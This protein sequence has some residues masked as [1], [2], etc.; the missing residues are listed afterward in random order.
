MYFQEGRLPLGKLWRSVQDTQDGFDLYSARQASFAWPRVDLARPLRPFWIISFEFTKVCW[1][2]FPSWE[3]FIGFYI[4]Y[5]PIS[6]VLA[7][8]F[9]VE[10]RILWKKLYWKGS[11][12]AAEMP[13]RASYLVYYIVWRVNFSKLS[14]EVRKFVWA[15]RT[16][17]T[18]CRVSFINLY[19]VFPKNFRIVFLPHASTV[20]LLEPY[21]GITCSITTLDGLKAFVLSSFPRAANL[22]IR[23]LTHKPFPVYDETF[24]EIRL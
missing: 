23:T 4:W 20:I 11:S 22:D 15:L 12:R 6:T 24:Y 2:R 17:I 5:Y 14:R 21:C 18:N 10:V 8:L 7:C 3:S 19:L 1:I 13:S 9:I 16:T